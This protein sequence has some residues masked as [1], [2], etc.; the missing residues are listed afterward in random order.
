M[1]IIDFDYKEKSNPMNMFNCK[2]MEDI[3][4]DQ[5]GFKPRPLNLGSGALLTV[6]FGTGIRTCLIIKFL[7][8]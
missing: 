7:A 4:M 3:M 8:P 1:P 5:W 6:L 2:G